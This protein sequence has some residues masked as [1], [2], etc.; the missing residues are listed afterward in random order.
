MEPGISWVRL[1]AGKVTR[2]RLIQLSVFAKHCVSIG[3]HSGRKGLVL[4]LKVCNVLLVQAL[5][6]GELSFEPRKVGRTAVS[7]CRD[8]LPRVIPSFARTLIRSGDRITIQL[9]L[10][11][12]GIYRVIPFKGKVKFDTILAPAPNLPDSFLTEWVWFLRNVFL[13]RVSEHTGTAL[14]DGGLDL[15]E[16]PQPF[17]IQSVSADRFEDPRITGFIDGLK[18]DRKT[19]RYPL[20]GTPTAY[21]HRFNAAKRW[22]VTPSSDGFIGL[23]SNL[24]LDYLRLI[25]GGYGTTKSLWTLL[26]DTADFMPMA[27]AFTRVARPE[28]LSSERLEGIG[29]RPNAHGYG[30]NLCG[31][32]ALLPEPAGKV[33]VVALADIWSQWAL[34][35]LH[36]WLFDILREIPQDGTFDQLRPVKLLLKKVSPTQ[37]IYSYDLSAATDCIPIAIQELLLAQIFGPAYAEAWA[38]LLVGRPYAIPKKVAKGLG[39]SSRFIR[40][41]TG[42]PMGAYSSWGML[43]F[44]HHA[45]VQ[46]CAYRAGIKG[47]FDLYAVLGDDV[48]IAHD[49]V[50][51]KYRALCRLLRVKIGLEKSLVSTGL[52]LE[53]AKRLFF[54]GEDIS[55]LPA[56]F[57]AA[58][59]SQSSVACALAA[60]TTRGTLS[61]FVRALGAGFKVASGV[62]TARWSNMNQR[63]RALCVSLTNPVIAT[64]F[65]FATWPEWLWSGS[66][67]TSRPLNKDMLTAFSPFCTSVQSVLVKPALDSLESMQE[68]LFFAEKLEDPVTRLT[69]ARANKALVDAERSVTLAS[70]ALR[71][72]Q[73]LN[74]KFNLVQVSAIL[75]QVWRSVDKAGLVPPASTKSTV[76][77]EVDPFALKVTSVFKH[78]TNLRALARPE[79]PSPLADDGQDPYSKISKGIVVS[80]TVLEQKPVVEDKQVSTQV[81]SPASDSDDDDDLPDM[82]HF[83]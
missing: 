1:V 60:W 55:G 21:A 52:T 61:N 57:W 53:F 32:L 37:A 41:G 63:A 59:Q 14:V 24:L 29:V 47:W 35:P 8:G 43:A 65:S 10:S 25:P 28:G 42:Q 11:F 50:A 77:K 71:H 38:N 66:A 70:E 3:R 15:L 33:R 36:D 58:A 12:F 5:P 17:V 2:S 51:R 81:D 49:G 40:Y 7:R 19:G 31:R 45:M 34:K 48:V 67:D 56:K 73:R 76:R 9:W 54:R 46:F 26:E 74:I 6:G 69:D 80:T 30:T 64:R 16:R 78:W 27:R 62:S 44:V 68:D 72:L 83:F 39:L 75:T 23:S 4:Y 22:T 20:T 79:A 82:S 13:P 18:L